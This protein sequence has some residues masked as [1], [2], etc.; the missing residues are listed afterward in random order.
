MADFDRK[1]VKPETLAAHAAGVG[2]EANGAV[3]PAI[4]PSTTFRRD[5]DYQ[6]IWRATY[7]R[8]DSPSYDAAEVTIATLEGG[9]EA[10]LFA[11]GMAAAAAIVQALRPG[12]HLVLQRTMYWG[13][14]DWIEEFAATWGLELDLIDPGNLD[15]LRQKLRPGATKLVWLESPANPTWDVVDLEAAAALA[16]EAGALTVADS[17]VAT[18]ILTRPLELGCDI[19]MHSATKYLNGH[20]DVVAGALVTARRDDVWGRIRHNREL[21]GASLGP[22]EAWL[23]QRGLRTLHL[24]VRQA[25]ANALAIAEHFAGHPAV[26]HVLYPGLPGHPR[27]EI[28]KRQMSGGFGGMMSIRL[29]GGEPAALAAAGQCR[30]FRPATSLGGVESLVEH[31]ATVEGPNSPVP[32]D[33]LRLSIG[34]EHV[35]DLIAD[36]EQAFA[37]GAAASHDIEARGAAE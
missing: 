6:P 23:L 10:I 20:S 32:R 19:V 13:V 27:H 14:R 34:V 8:G 26:S 21:G 18:P 4:Q 30:I 12:D 11:S 7:G 28:A 16:K 5:K 15:E 35:D 22:F 17:T 3:V 31:R 37:A 25:S 24:R 1:S 9:E 2:D 36:L 33:M 29:S